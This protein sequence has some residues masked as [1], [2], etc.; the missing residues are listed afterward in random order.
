MKV[1]QAQWAEFDRIATEAE[2]FV[3]EIF[4]DHHAGRCREPSADLIA[5]SAMVRRE[6]NLMFEEL[7]DADKPVAP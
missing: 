7:K 3:A 1:T 6:A 4:A 2:A 5:L